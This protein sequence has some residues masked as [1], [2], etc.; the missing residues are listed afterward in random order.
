MEQFYRRLV[1]EM[2][3]RAPNP[4]KNVPLLTERPPRPLTP[5]EE[6]ERIFALFDHYGIDNAFKDPPVALLKLVRCLGMDFVPGFQPKK[7][8]GAEP[9]WHPLDKALLLQEFC[10]L[11]RVHPEK[12]ERE[13]TRLMAENPENRERKLSSDA[14]RSIINHAQKPGVSEEI[15]TELQDMLN[16]AQQF[17][18]HSKSL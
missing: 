11:R 16:F 1:R 13:I 15:L 17:R 14:I 12:T 4:F 3:K 5:A 10:H 18:N 7:R 9:K 2:S 6:A 8:P